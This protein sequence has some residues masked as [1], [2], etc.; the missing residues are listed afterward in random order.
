MMSGQK[1]PKAKPVTSDWKKGWVEP[2][3]KMKVKRC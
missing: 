1:K 2:Y 3:E